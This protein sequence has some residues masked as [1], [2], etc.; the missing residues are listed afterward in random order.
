MKILFY[1]TETTGIPSSLGR[2]SENL[3][4]Y[5]WL[6]QISAI[7]YTEDSTELKNIDYYVER[8]NMRIDNSYIHG[9]TPEI[10]EKKG[11]PI[12]YVIKKFEEICSEADLIVCHNYAFDSTIVRTELKRNK[13]PDFLSKKPSFCTMTE[14]SWLS[15]GISLQNLHYEIYGKR[16]D[17]HHNSL[18]DT[19]ATADC[20]FG[21][22]KNG[23]LEKK[24]GTYH[25]NRPKNAIESIHEPDL[26]IDN[27]KFYNAFSIINESQKN[28]FLTGK[29]G[30]GK[31]TF[32]KYL[33][34]KTSKY[35]ITLTFT[36][37]AAINA[38][39]QTI[40]SFFQLDHR[41]FLPDDSSLD[42]EKIYSFLRYTTNKREI[43]NKLEIIIIDEI[44]MVK[45]DTIDAIDKI[46]RIFRKKDMPFGGVQMIFIGDLFQL[47]PIQ[48]PEWNVVSE[49][50]DS[51]YFFDAKIIHKLIE[52]SNLVRIELD[53]VYRQKEIEFIDILN[54]IRVGNHSIDDLNRLNQNKIGIENLNNL[55]SE[56]HI[57]LTTTNAKINTINYKKLA[58]IDSPEVQ[59]NGLSE[60]V[61][62]ADLKV[63]PQLLKLKI[64]AQ[65]ML[66]K[67]TGRNY[68]GKIGKVVK[69]ADDFIEVIFDDDN[70]PI[71]VGLVVWENIKYTYNKEKH[72]ID[73]NVVG[74]YVQFPLKL[75]WAITVHK[76]QGLTFN[77]VIADVSKA[78]SVGQ[79]YVALSR[80]TSLSNLK[81]IGALQKEDIKID[82]RVVIFS[83][84]Q[85]PDV[86]IK[87]Y[88]NEGKIDTLYGI[89]KALLFDTKVDEVFKILQS[90]VHSKNDIF[91]AVFMDSLQEYI[92]KHTYYQ[93]SVINLIKGS[94]ELA[95][96]GTNNDKDTNNSSLL[97]NYL[98]EL[99]EAI[100]PLSAKLKS[101]SEGLK[102]LKNEDL[103]FSPM[104]PKIDRHLEF[105]I[106]VYREKYT[107]FANVD[108][109]LKD[110]MAKWFL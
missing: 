100:L 31:T 81:L 108:K 42:K 82:Q 7:L 48:G 91:S 63:A 28:I 39:G 78:F 57:L 83:K 6:L 62:P 97:K 101:I 27:S 1:D 47:P 44:S 76:S 66:L 40:N 103:R 23:W 89:F 36:G 67:N 68:N 9:I 59:F 87:G 49:F 18:Y 96:G 94:S 98:E 13:I 37:A 71:K 2:R 5:P 11:K 106:E 21:M 25:F 80:C 17:N 73:E 29:A 99:I 32:L 19:K 20:F 72:L 8:K 77:K 74:T 104:K 95:N 15:R 60:G 12:G 55:L 70:A 52:S 69:I 22:I 30:T 86:I 35:S 46:L 58:E 54:R 41:P 84:N 110:L 64:G 16:F 34:Q 85:T 107:E 26:D 10:L 56:N 33:R 88:L 109:E 50:Y 61:F 45:A 79:V 102:M 51:H 3:E 105:C 65:V 14:C 53:K 92:H 90:A 4:R 43:L 93:Q 24:N 38:G 75:A